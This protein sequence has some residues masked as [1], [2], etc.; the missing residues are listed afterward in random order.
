M[1]CFKSCFPP[2]TWRGPASP[3]GARVQTTV[4]N[5]DTAVLGSCKRFEERQV[6]LLLSNLQAP[7]ASRVFL[8]TS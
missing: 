1:A 5:L 7:H 8:A 6:C 3:A 4:N 2:V